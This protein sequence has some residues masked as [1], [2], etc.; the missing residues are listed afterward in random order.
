[1]GHSFGVALQQWKPGFLLY[2]FG[3]V[4]HLVHLR[5]VS[6]MGS[7]WSG[8]GP[9]G[10][11]P[12]GPPEEGAAPA[13]PELRPPSFRTIMEASACQSKCL[14]CQETDRQGER[15][16]RFHKGG[17]ISC[18]KYRETQCGK[19]TGDGM[20]CCL[21]YAWLLEHKHCDRGYW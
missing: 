11:L 9:M 5:S 2:R 18:G 12:P 15:L 10:D 8:A 21:N 17:G 4:E 3:A 19:D 7:A 6:L 1:L 20:G 13:L 16:L 14:G